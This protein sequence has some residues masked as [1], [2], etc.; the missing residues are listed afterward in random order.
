MTEDARWP[1]AAVWL[2]QSSQLNKTAV[3]TG[4]ADLDLAVVGIPAHLTSISK[5]GANLTPT[6]IREALQRYSTWS[7][8][9]ATEIGN[10]RVFDFGD[11]TDPDSPEGEAR[12]IKLVAEASGQAKLTVVLGGDNSVTYAA[13]HGLAADL[14]RTALITFD[15]HHDLRDGISNGSPVRRLIEAGLPGDQVV[16]IGIAD[17]SNSPEYAG[18][19]RDYGVRVIP[20]SALR[21][22]KP[23]EIWKSALAALPE[24]DQIFVDIDVDVCD[25]SVVPACPAAAP[26][27]LSADELRQFAY[28]IGAEPLVRAFDI[29]EIDASNDAPDARTVRLAALL[30]LEAAAGLVSRP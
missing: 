5:T 24:V 16:Q 3:A 28:L 13:T 9:H 25:R 26:G 30:I 20:R 18:R 8:E 1:R 6:A 12:S 2:A 15:A 10:L 17:F 14:R 19:A 29:T 11:S 4:V 22:Q 23:S 21:E 7:W 27:G